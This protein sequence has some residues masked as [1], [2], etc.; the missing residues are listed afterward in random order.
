MSMSPPNSGQKLPQENPE[1]GTV[2]EGAEERCH[3][4]STGPGVH[5]PLPALY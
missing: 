2:S 3:F 4:V 5:V 1:K